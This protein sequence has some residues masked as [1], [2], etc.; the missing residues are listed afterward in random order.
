MCF[1]GLQALQGVTFSLGAAEHLSIIGPNGSGKTTLLDGIAGSVPLDEG[2]VLLDGVPLSGMPEQRARLG[3][4]RTFQRTQVFPS[5]TVADHLLVALRARHGSP[6]LWRDLLRVTTRTAN[7]RETITNCLDHVGLSG[8]EDVVVGTLG[9]GTCR[10]V[11]LARALV[12]EP[13]VLLLDECSSGLDDEETRLLVDV[14]LETSARTAMAVVAI[15][16][17]LTV[18]SA[19]GG[20]TLVLVNGAIVGRGRLDEVLAMPKVAS[21]YLGEQL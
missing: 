10:M 4:A 1:G 8:K 3:I 18:V 6:R 16:H 21:A 14:V 5:L 20:E 15:E 13:R 19:F 17:D 9:L 12:V 2:L 7:E 11:E